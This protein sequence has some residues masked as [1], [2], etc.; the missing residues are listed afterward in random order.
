MGYR[1]VDLS[2]NSILGFYT[3]FGVLAEDLD[4]IRNILILELRSRMHKHSVS[5]LCSKKIEIF[6][7]EGIYS[8]V[9]KD[10]DIDGFSFFKVNFLSRISFFFRWVWLFL[11]DS[12][13]ALK[14]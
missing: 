13:R 1:K 4:D 14:F 11:F 2:G 3:T 6:I 10:L 8:G 12:V 9:E 7:I 5:P